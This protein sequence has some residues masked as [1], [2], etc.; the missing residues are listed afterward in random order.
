MPVTIGG[1]IRTNRGRARFDLQEAAIAGV[2]VPRRVVQELVAYYSR[3]ANHPQ[4]RRLEEEFVL[5]AGIQAIELSRGAAVV[6][7]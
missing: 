4:G 7:Q 3:T 6:V 5:P 2:P 1:V